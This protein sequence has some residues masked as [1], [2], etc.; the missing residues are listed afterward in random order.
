HN[1]AGNHNHLRIQNVNQVRQTDAEVNAHAA[2]DLEREF[3]ALQP[4]FKDR[5]R[6][7]VAARVQYR[8]GITRTCFA[9]HAHDRSRRRK[10][11]QAAAATARTRNAAKW[12]DTHVPNLR[13]RA[14]D[15]APQFAIENN[16]ATD[17]GAEC[18]TDDRA[19]TTRRALPHLANSR[20][21]RIVF[22]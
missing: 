7:Q 20:S 11:F 18:Y 15:T 12:I 19:T 13:G 3:I 17:A 10:Y 8:L 2:K 9:R 14:V 6:A 5:L 22:E 4:R 16:S 21:V 1:A